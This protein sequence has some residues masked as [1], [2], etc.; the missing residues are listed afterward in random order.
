MIK[1][2]SEEIWKDIRDCT[3]Y[4]ISNLGRVLN[5]KTKKFLSPSMRNNLYVEVTFYINKKSKIKKLHRLIAEAFIPNPENKPTVNHID[6]NPQNNNI[7]NLEWSTMTEQNTAANKNIQYY[8]NNANC[9]EI[10]QIDSKTNEIVQTFKGFST[11]AKWLLENN[12]TTLKLRSIIRQITTAC[13]NKNQSCFGFFWEYAD[14]ADEDNELWMEIPVEVISKTKYFISNKG[15]L[16]LPS[17]QIKSNYRSSSG[18][19][20]LRIGETKY[21]LHRLVALTFLPNPE[22]R[23][24]VNHKDGNK[25]NNCLENLEWAT[26]LE[27]NLHKIETGLSNSTKEIIQYDK[28]MNFINEFKSINDASRALKIHKN[29]IIHNLKTNCKKT[30]SGFQFRYRNNLNTILQQQT[31][32]IE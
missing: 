17:N 21:L 24:F 31:V 2:M 3:P 16:K 28:N 18:Y 27:N 22:N 7:L 30:K 32:S 8:K 12:L 4:Q 20:R 26:A 9:R 5:S 29:V 14:L 23:E 15:R 6:K 11:L 1:K 19:K 25:L 10:Y 13:K